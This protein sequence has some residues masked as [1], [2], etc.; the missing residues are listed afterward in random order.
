MKVGFFGNTNNYPFTLARGMRRLGHDVLF[1][2]DRPEPLNRPESRFADIPVPYPGWIVDVSP[3][4]LH[5][6]LHPPPAGRARAISLLAGCDAVVLNMLG[7]SLLPEIRRPSIVMLTGSDLED[8]ADYGFAARYLEAKYGSLRDVL[9]GRFGPYAREAASM[10]RLVA[11][12]RAGIRRAAAVNYFTRGFVPRGDAL[13]DRIGVPDRR[14]MFFIMTD[15]ETIRPRPMPDNPVVRVFSVARLTWK[16]PRPR[17]D[18]PGQSSELD[19]KGSD[20]MVRGLAR[21]RRATGTPLEI[22][23]VKKGRHVPETMELAAAEGI[24]DQISW[25]EEMTQKEVLEEYARADIVFDQLGNAVL[26]MGGVDAMAAGRPVIANAR[27]GIMDDVFG[28]PSPICQASTPQ[29][30]CAQLERL[31]FD[32]GERER[33][34]L[35]SRRF[36]EDY[37][38]AERSARL[39]LERLGS[40]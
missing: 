24:G 25:L 37:F 29:E 18:V 39:C 35:L 31:A 34:G 22:R 33:V 8:Y 20:I 14:R 12:Q 3:L 11:A 40:R 23:L 27:P 16:T 5:I 30:V 28:A 21:F 2:V 10:I 38:S 1:I 32:R 4:D 26:G 19:Y 9:P 36:A 15:L 17:A 6:P 7:P 13:L